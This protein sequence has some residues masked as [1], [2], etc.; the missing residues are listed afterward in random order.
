MLD[1][2]FRR[3]KLEEALEAYKEALEQ[4]EDAKRIQRKERELKRRNNLGPII[5]QAIHKG[6][7]A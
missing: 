5:T 4:V 3:K 2:L 7:G 1:S 6:R